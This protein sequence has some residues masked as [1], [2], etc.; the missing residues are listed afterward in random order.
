MQALFLDGTGKTSRSAAAAREG[1]RVV[2]DADDLIEQARVAGRCVA[3][4]PMAE[5]DGRA[6]GVL[7]KLRR[8]APE[9]AT[10]LIAERE[11]LDRA[12]DVAARGGAQAILIAGDWRRI[13][14]PRW[15]S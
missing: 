9:A 6:D 7:E 4:L 8:R 2:A 12:L 10:C 5:L 1:T 3:L 15:R 13:G 11:A 14:A